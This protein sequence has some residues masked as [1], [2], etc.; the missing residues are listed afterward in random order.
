[1]KKFLFMI[2][3]VALVGFTSCS[4]EENLPEPTPV[5][6]V[7]PAPAP[8]IDMSLHIGTWN[9]DSIYYTYS[10]GSGFNWVLNQGTMNFDGSVL[11]WS[12]GSTDNYTL[13]GT[14][15]TMPANATDFVVHSVSG[16]A[17]M[18][19]PTWVDPSIGVKEYYL[20]K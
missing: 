3:A 1:M 2:V 12:S 8:S 10:D 9:V 19:T 17:M 15:I 5:E 18:L 11:T 7:T 14:T 13:S 16:N 6:V 20:S 4:K